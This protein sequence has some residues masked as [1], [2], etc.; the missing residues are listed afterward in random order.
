VAHHERIGDRVLGMLAEDVYTWKL[1]RQDLGLSRAQPE[2]A[3][4]ELL[5][6][7]TGGPN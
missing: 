2:I 5:E 7:L 1:F 3:L 6:P 4:R